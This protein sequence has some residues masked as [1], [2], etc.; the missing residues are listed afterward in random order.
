MET[1]VDSE[2]GQVTD[3]VN[4]WDNAKKEAVATKEAFANEHELRVQLEGLL[5]QQEEDFGKFN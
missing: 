3:L 4:S 2:R 5:S 1:I